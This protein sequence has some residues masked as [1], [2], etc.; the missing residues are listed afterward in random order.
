MRKEYNNIS[1]EKSRQFQR[2]VTPN[3]HRYILYTRT[4]AHI[5]GGIKTIPNSCPCVV[6]QKIN[7][8]GGI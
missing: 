5:W 8:G 6:I 2:V 3:A 4:Y 1:M 7:V